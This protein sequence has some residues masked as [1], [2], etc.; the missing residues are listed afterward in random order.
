MK[1][2]AQNVLRRIRKMRGRKMRAR[3]VDDCVV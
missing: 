1:R 2:A 3:L